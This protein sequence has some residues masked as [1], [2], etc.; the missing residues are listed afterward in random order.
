MTGFPNRSIFSL[1]SALMIF[2][3]VHYTFLKPADLEARGTR[4][5]SNVTSEKAVEASA[6]ALSTLG[7]QVTQKSKEAGVVKTAP[8]DILVTQKTETTVDRTPLA[9]TVRGAT[10]SSTQTRDGLAWTL[11]ISG[12]G[13]GV[14]IVALPRAY[15]NGSELVEDAFVAEVMDPRFNA[16]WREIEGSM[17]ASN[18]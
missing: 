8:Q 1:S 13:D 16:L 18:P 3:C 4:T 11:R 2:S 9:N 14:K 12:A 6:V 10:S 5:F 17:S 15:R 7:Y